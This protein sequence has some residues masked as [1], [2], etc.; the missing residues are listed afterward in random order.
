GP[1]SR[2]TMENEG[3]LTWQDR[4]G[5]VSRITPTAEL[6]R[7]DNET[8]TG[9][10]K[11]IDDRAIRSTG[12]KVG[13]RIAVRRGVVQ[14]VVNDLE[15]RHDWH[16]DVAN[17]IDRVYCLCQRGGNSCRAKHSR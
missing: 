1:P 7:D 15:T 8:S 10:E 4:L 3:S 14:R 11:P 9:L 6:L 17:R 5:S 16:V 2:S 13:H 12:K